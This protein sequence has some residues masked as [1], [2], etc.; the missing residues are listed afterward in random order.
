[1]KKCIAVLT[2]GYDNIVKYDKLIKRN[3]YIDNNLINK[4]IDI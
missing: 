3:K 1:M 4:D 2:R